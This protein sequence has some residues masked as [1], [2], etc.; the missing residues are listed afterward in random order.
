[1]SDHPTPFTVDTTREDDRCLLTV[2]GE[3]DAATTVDLESAIGS[4]GPDVTGLEVD[5]TGVSFIDSSGLR[6]LVMARQ[7]AV[8]QGR[9]F[10]IVGSS[11]AV[12]R[13]LELTGLED[14]RG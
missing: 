11:K 7:S 10:S 1:M 3:L 2:A 9:R 5:L 12:D 6:T 4:A 14:L 8:E 13:L